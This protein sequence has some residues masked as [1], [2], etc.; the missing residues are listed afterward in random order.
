MPVTCSVFGNGRHSTCR[1]FSVYYTVYSVTWPTHVRY[2]S[3]DQWCFEGGREESVA[4][5]VTLRGLR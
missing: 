4:E 1:V 2:K 3:H 5:P